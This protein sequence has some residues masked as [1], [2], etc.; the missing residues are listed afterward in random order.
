MGKKKSPVIALTLA[1]AFWATASA[2]MAGEPLTNEPLRPLEAVAGLDPR[3]VELGDTLFHDP[4]LSADDTVSCAFCH[5]LGQGGVDRQQFSS[6]IGG[7][8]GG[9]NA[10][11]VYNA[12]Y[13]LAQFWDGRA[14]DLEEQAGGPV[15]NPVE[16]GAAWPDVIAKLKADPDYVKAFGALYPDGITADNVR[17]AIAAFE[18]S[19]ITTGSPFDLYLMGEEDALTPDARAGYRLFKDYGCAACHQGA[20]VGGNMYQ[21]MGAIGD[22]FGDRGGLTKAD[23]GRYN[24]TGRE[25]DKHVFKVPSLRVA[26]LTPPYFHDG[27][28]ETLEDAIATMS[29]YQLGRE[30]PDE[31]VNRIAAFLRA[32]VGS[33]ARLDKAE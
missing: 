29:R 4:R 24:V 25:E 22:Y 32:L 30:M 13:N 26:A 15:V 31:D 27:S 10:P 5:D 17:A 14:A 7:A 9:I 23:L 33:H 21:T 18:R 3:Q 1:A 16:M 12:A 20:N 11:T 8:M 19:L 28:R 6:G 2:V